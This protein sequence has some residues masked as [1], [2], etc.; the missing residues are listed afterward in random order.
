M[1]RRAVKKRDETRTK[2]ERKGQRVRGRY[3]W[4]KSRRMIHRRMNKRDCSSVARLLLLLGLLILL[5]LLQNYAAAAA[6][7]AMHIGFR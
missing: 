3:S 1:W 7:V 6:A 4:E 5:L 2:K